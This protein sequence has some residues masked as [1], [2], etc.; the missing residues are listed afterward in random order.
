MKLY[1]LIGYP[2][3]HSFSARYFAEKFRR[4]SLTGVEYRNFPIEDIAMLPGI[5]AG[6]PDLKGF[7][8][9]IPYKEAVIPYL[10]SIS[11]EA[12]A[13]GAVNCVKI[14]GNLKLG[15]NTDVAG[16]RRSLTAMI[17]NE[18]PNAL[19][20]GSGGASKAVEYVL[21]ELG[22]EHKIV[23]RKA[24]AGRLGYEDL[25]EGVVRAHRLIVNATPLGTFPDTG[26]FPDIPYTGIGPDHFLFDLV[27]NPETT[28]FMRRGLERG[29][30]VKN[31]YEMLVGQAEEA[32]S[33]WNG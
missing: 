19:I 26:T 28:Q 32:W 12:R 20:L 33:I 25:D 18:R 29:A 1:G 22:I 14:A 11:D 3:E 8:V 21:R 27:Y 10:D 4:L 24:G 6:N 15:Y 17:G 31:G 5:L 7:N 2:L 9:T 13:I 16:F 30:S 23:S